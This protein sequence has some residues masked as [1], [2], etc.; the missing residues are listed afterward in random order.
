[1]GMCEGIYNMKPKKKS[2]IISNK[3]LKV[4]GYNA[5]I[6]NEIL[7]LDST[8]NT[9]T[10][11]EDKNKIDFYKPKC[12][13]YKKY[14]GKNNID[15]DT[16]VNSRQDKSVMSSNNGNKK[17]NNTGNNSYSYSNSYDNGNM[18]PYDGG[19]MIIDGRLDMNKIT[20]CQD[21][22]T[23]KLYNEFIG[24]DDDNEKENKKLDLYSSKKKIRKN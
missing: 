14:Q 2:K 23:L 12:Y 4:N 13:Q 7:H 24:N 1:M 5:P 8:V 22:N 16:L 6:N 19:E 17:M 3:K 10:R 20:N 11:T 18:S 15:N 9:T 21:I